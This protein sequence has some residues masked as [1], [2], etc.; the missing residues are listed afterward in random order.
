M[1]MIRSVSKTCSMRERGEYFRRKES[2]YEMITRNFSDSDLDLGFN[3]RFR[4][5]C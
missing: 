2:D 3:N 4:S 5:T 1:F